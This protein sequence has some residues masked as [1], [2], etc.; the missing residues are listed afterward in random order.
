MSENHN[1]QTAIILFADIAGYTAKMEQS[2]KDALD[3]LEKFKGTLEEQVPKHNGEI[4]NFY[5]D[6][7]LVVFPTGKDAISCSKILQHYFRDE[8][9]MPV[10]IGLDKGPVVF[11]EGNV[12]GEFVNRSSRIESIS[13]S[14]GILYSK[15]VYEEISETPDIKSQA[16]GSFKF[17]NI[18]EPVEVYSILADGFPIPDRNK[19]LKQSKVIQRTFIEEN[20]RSIVLG[21]GILGIILLSASLFINKDS[22]DDGSIK[23]VAVLP[24]K[25][26]SDDAKNQYFGDGMTDAIL[27][28]LARIKGINVTSRTSVDKYKSTELG[29]PEIAEELNVNYIL[30]GTVQQYGEEMRI[31]AQLIELPSDKHLW[32]KQYDVSFNL[33]DILKVQKE[34]STSIAKELQVRLNPEVLEQIEKT[35]TNS[36]EA[37]EAFLKGK[38]IVT[39]YY[40]TQDIKYLLE[41]ETYFKEAL[42]HD[43]EF[44]EAY[45]NLAHTFWLNRYNAKYLQRNFLDTALLLIDKALSINPYLA[46]GY[47]MRGSYYFEQSQFALAEQNYRR[48]LEIEPNNAHTITNLGLVCY[49]VNGNYKEGIELFNRALELEE[50]DNI[51]ETH[52]KFGMLYMDIGIFDKA[53]Y[54]FKKAMETNPRSTGLN[55]CYQAQ[56]KNKE[57]HEFLVQYLDTFPERTDLL[58]NL[59]MSYMEIGD[60][61]KSKE[62]WDPFIEDLDTKGEEHYLNKFRGKYG[63]LLMKV[64]E[65]EK[66]K[67]QIEMC[68][69]YLERSVYM[70]R[71]V[72]S[73]GYIQYDLAGN[74]A[75]L[76]DKKKAFKWLEEFDTFGWKW[77]SVYFIQHDLFFKNIRKEKQF[78]GMI[79]KALEEKDEIVANL[80]AEGLL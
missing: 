68:N 20:W 15:P 70:R 6:G 52:E 41:A 74:Y 72:A 13:M 35:P 77:S 75:V 51:T 3:W 10:R 53:E 60:I 27:D 59:A 66:A 71:A 7:C 44:A 55:W 65:K 62:I 14:G 34:V 63:L 2:E 4:K 26:L 30:E 17:K 39:Q 54:H 49:L 42:G 36:I 28:H 64:G 47:Q 37:Y 25:N 5:G 21:L 12:F 56:G 58:P 46:N 40:D 33:E 76:N 23:S 69:T 22:F 19:I 11:K 80:K 38:E 43:E 29:L 9:Q 67:E 18:K 45:L 61:Q 1:K 8:Y 16:L 79:K 57:N 32:S 31:I 78:K 48:T 50:A 24:F 73:G